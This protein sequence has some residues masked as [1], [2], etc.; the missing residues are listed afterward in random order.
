MPAKSIEG[1]FSHRIVE[2]LVGLAKEEWGLRWSMAKLTVMGDFLSGMGI[3][4]RCYRVG[5]W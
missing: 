2:K 5:F 1:D 3:I 4:I